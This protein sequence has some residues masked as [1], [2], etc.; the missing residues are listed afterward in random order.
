MDTMVN[1]S[2][3][4]PMIPRAILLVSKNL[5]KIFL[6][7]KEDPINSG[8]GRHM[9]NRLWRELVVDLLTLQLP[10]GHH[11]L[12]TEYIFMHAINIFPGQ[13]L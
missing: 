13:F 10:S 1:C 7:I 8:P 3:E 2:M 11:F 9:L 6:I 4:R 12:N 5:E